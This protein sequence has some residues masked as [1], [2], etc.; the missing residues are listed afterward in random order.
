MCG[1]KRT[2]LLTDGTDRSFERS[3]V[4]P[5][6]A[7]NESTDHPSSSCSRATRPS[8]FYGHIILFAPGTSALDLAC[9]CG[10]LVTKAIPDYPCN[11]SSRGWRV[12]INIASLRRAS[13]NRDRRRC[14]NFQHS[15]QAR[16]KPLARWCPW[17][18]SPNFPRV[19]LESQW[20]KAPVK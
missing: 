10:Q 15:G 18:T 13:L 4:I 7:A 14:Q 1:G 6:A 3:L 19:A 8:V 17:R 16:P 2:T 12:F 11:R 5:F 20:T 9:R